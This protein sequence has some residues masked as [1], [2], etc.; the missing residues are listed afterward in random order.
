[1]KKNKYGLSSEEY[2]RIYNVW[3]NI[4][5]RCNNPKSKSYK[6]YGGR[7]ITNEFVE[8]EDFIEWALENGYDNDLSIER[9]D[10]NGNYSKA[11]CK[12]I[13][14][15]EQCYNTQKTN[16]ITYKGKTQSLSKWAEELGFNKHTLQTRYNRGERNVDVLFS[17]L[18][19]D[20]TKYDKVI[21]YDLQGNIIKIYDSV[22]EAN[23]QTGIAC[24]NIS[25]VCKGKRKSAGGYMWKYTE[26][27]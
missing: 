9:V 19:R 26:R 7:E 27:K 10:V 24:C 17:N 16:W 8:F 22:R 13:P 14:I 20:V 11:N 21:Q 18:S 2:A 6:S 3:K 23:L 1:M 5:E 12:W 15:K 25:R 4:N